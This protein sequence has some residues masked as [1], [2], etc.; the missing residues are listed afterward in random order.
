MATKYAGGN[1]AVASLIRWYE[2]SNERGRD[3]KIQNTPWAYAR[4]ENGEPIT[5]AH[6]LIYRMRQDL[7]DA[8]PNPFE[9]KPGKK[10]YYDWFR[11]Q[12]AIEHPELVPAVP[13]QPEAQAT[14]QAEERTLEQPDTPSSSEAAGLP[15]GNGMSATGNGSP[16]WPRVRW[17]LRKTITDP[18]YGPTLVH[19]TLQILRQNGISGIK[20]R[21]GRP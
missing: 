1:K 17:H 20:H 15:S 12:A 18:R 8:Y 5:R 3:E 21:L 6:R 4:F 7:Q 11:W 10:S 9:A 13:I 16:F 14:S 19:K 2:E